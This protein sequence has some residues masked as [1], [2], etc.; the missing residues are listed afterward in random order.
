MH[1]HVLSPCLKKCLPVE[2]G[3][4]TF[5]AFRANN[6]CRRPYLYA[7]LDVCRC[8]TGVHCLIAHVCSHTIL[9]KPVGSIALSVLLHQSLSHAAIDG[10]HTNLDNC[11][12][13]KLHLFY[14]FLHLSQSSFAEKRGIDAQLATIWDMII[15]CLQRDHK[16][17]F[18][19]LNRIYT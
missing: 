14:C 18:Y 12:A 5:F 2:Q 8:V 4:R 16:L 15:L 6:H 7:L 1:D 9:Q 11:I 13:R 3:A 10:V 19:R 17:H